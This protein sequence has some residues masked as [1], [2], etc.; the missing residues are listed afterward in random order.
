MDGGNT[1][2]LDTQEPEK[3]FGDLPRDNK[4]VEI[5]LDI[6][7]NGTAT[8]GSSSSKSSKTE[9]YVQKSA[10]EMNTLE[11]PVFTTIVSYQNSLFRK[12]TFFQFL[13]KSNSLSNFGPQE[14]KK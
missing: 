13:G 4:E 8:F 6:K 2:N 9:T 7:Q 10:E 12:E 11:E 14:T 3:T 5:S 1:N